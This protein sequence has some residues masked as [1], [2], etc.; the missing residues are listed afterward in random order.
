MSVFQSQSAA[1]D[2]AWRRD[3]RDIHTDDYR[4]RTQCG[5]EPREASDGWP[6]THVKGLGSTLRTEWCRL[7]EGKLGFHIFLQDCPRMLSI[8]LHPV[9]SSPTWNKLD[10]ILVDLCCEIKYP[11][12]PHTTVKYSPHFLFVKWDCWWKIV[13]AYVVFQV[14]AKKFKLKESPFTSCPLS[15]TL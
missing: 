11:S 1:W 14:T 15:Q 2:K 7:Q 13:I 9:R 4:T 3:L 10:G 8:W 12:I 5:Q 6:G